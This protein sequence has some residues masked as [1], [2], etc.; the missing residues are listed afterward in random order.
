MKKSLILTVA[1]GASLALNASPHEEEEVSS[2][3]TSQYANSVVNTPSQTYRT[4]QNSG[5]SMQIGVDTYISDTITLVNLPIS[6]VYQNKFGASLYISYVETDIPYIDKE[7]GIGDTTLEFT[8]NMG[9]FGDESFEN[10]I[11]GL[12]Y[13]FPSGDEEKYLG[14]GASSIGAFWDTSYETEGWT[15]IVNILFNYY[16]DDATI[17][18]DTYTYGYE[19]TDWIGIKHKCL[20]S[21]KVYTSLKLNWQSVG[22]TDIK[23]SGG[24]G[25]TID[26]YDI[27][28][29]TLQWDSY[30]IIPMVP[31]KAGIKVPVYKS[32]NVDPDVMFFVGIG[33]LLF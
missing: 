5:K 24:G 9:N 20:L 21:D 16:I 30:Q 6:Y 28:D 15:I 11:F 18:G 17:S 14:M 19:S 27:L 12:R 31:I 25:N 23:W 7:S 3:M 13:T 4:M 32:D 2:S 22:D 8:Y 10:N 33:G 29:V 1:L 26:G